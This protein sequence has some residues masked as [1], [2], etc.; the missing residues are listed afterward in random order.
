LLAQSLQNVLLIPKISDLGKS[1]IPPTEKKK[2]LKRELK[3]GD[4]L[5]QISRICYIPMLCGILSSA[6]KTELI[7]MKNGYFSVGIP[8]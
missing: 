7:P 1:T 3:N 2:P 6:V 5:L 4:A 8:L